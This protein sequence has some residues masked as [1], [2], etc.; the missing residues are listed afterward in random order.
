MNDE[1]SKSRGDGHQIKGLN[2]S[3]EGHNTSPTN[4]PQCKNKTHS[5]HTPH[6][7]HTPDKIRTT[8]NSVHTSSTSCTQPTSPHCTKHITPS[9]PPKSAKQIKP[10]ATPKTPKRKATQEINEPTNKKTR[11]HDSRTESKTLLKLKRRGDSETAQSPNKRLL[12]TV[13]SVCSQGEVTDLAEEGE[14]SLQNSEEPPPTDFASTTAPQQQELLSPTAPTTDIL[15]SSPTRESLETSLQLG[16]AND[17][18]ENTQ[19]ADEGL[20]NT[21]PANEGLANTQPAD[22]ADEGLANTQPADLSEQESKA[23]IDG[24]QVQN[25]PHS[26]CGAVVSATSEVEAQTPNQD[27]EGGKRKKKSRRREAE[28]L[29]EHTQRFQG[30]GWGIQEEEK[31]QSETHPNER[32]RNHLPHN[33]PDTNT[34]TQP[35]SSPDTHIATNTSPQ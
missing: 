11:K 30:F 28:M 7:P 32:D 10:P 12:W 21:Q 16:S 17:S 3:Q 1:L 18:L 9:T 15:I 20:A 29:Q 13:S 4:S 6:T 2:F 19:P 14:S 8:E 27:T 35:S 24:T 31:T 25:S 5:P 34:A 26:S 23:G 33:S 22:E